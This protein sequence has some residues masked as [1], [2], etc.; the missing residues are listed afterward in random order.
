VSKQVMFYTIAF[1]DKDEKP[2]DCS[3]MEFFENIESC[4]LET[5]NE[6]LLI[7]EIG[8]KTV[9]LFPFFRNMDSN[10]LVIPLGKLKDT[11]KPYGYNKDEKKLQPLT[12]DMFDI[13]SI[14]YDKTWNILMMTVN[15]QGPR[16]QTIIDYFN[17][18]IPDNYAY[19]VMIRPIF[20][21]NGLDEVRNAPLVRD[22]TFKLNLSKSVTKFYQNEIDENQVT[23]LTKSMK[24]L[25][26]HAKNDSGAKGLILTMNL[27]DSRKGEDTLDTR[28][29][30]SL[31]D[32]INIDEQFVDEIT[33]YYKD[34]KSVPI[35]RAKL[36]NSSVIV[37]HNFSLREN[38]ISPEFFVNHMSE[39]ISSQGRRFNGALEKYLKIFLPNEEYDFE[40]V[41]NYLPDNL[42][43]RGEENDG[44]EISKQSGINMEDHTTKSEN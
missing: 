37:Y 16:L 36:K 11:N 3:I 13:T 26:G 41:K 7:R 21:N 5:V 8:G 10:Q 15:Q 38:Q 17:S 24:S 14:A 2:I 35:S 33:V 25:I 30:L 20:Y 39:A 9:R 23:S 28:S 4:F 18:F 34:G 6:D 43:N 12:M 44:E 19:K 32:S 40:L 29:I 31:L 42:H 27:G 22:V 1:E